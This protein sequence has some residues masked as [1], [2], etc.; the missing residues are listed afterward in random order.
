MADAVNERKFSD[1]FNN[2]VNGMLFNDDF[3]DSHH[4]RC[5]LQLL[6]NSRIMARAK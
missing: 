1:I 5:A 6:K 4:E 3:I 2:T